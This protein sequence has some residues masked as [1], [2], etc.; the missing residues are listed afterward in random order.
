MRQST[1]PLLAVTL[2]CACGGDPSG[3]SRPELAGTYALTELRFDP[4]GVLP[5]VD[6]LPRVSGAPRLV[7]AP[8]GEAQLVF[9]DP[10]TGL[11]T[12]VTGA[13]STPDQGARIDFGSDTGFRQILLSRRMLFTFAAPGTLTFQGEAPDSVQRERLVTLVPEWAEEQLLDPVPGRLTVVFTRRLVSRG[14]GS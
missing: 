8:G 12:T 1:F 13:Y 5:E 2:L 6:L 3:P 14:S 11:V 4:R 9:E 7:L 10:A